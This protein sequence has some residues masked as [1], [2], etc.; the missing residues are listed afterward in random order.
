[1][2]HRRSASAWSHPSPT[3]ALGST[4]RTPMSSPS[5]RF[6][7]AMR[8][9][10]TRTSCARTQTSREDGASWTPFAA[11]SRSDSR[12]GW[13]RALAPLEARKPG[14]ARAPSPSGRVR[15]DAPR[16]REP[17]HAGRGSPCWPSSRANASSDG[18]RIFRPGNFC[19]SQWRCG[20][21]IESS[22]RVRNTSQLLQTAWVMCSASRCSSPCVISSA[23]MPSS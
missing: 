12:A 21:M 8:G 11:T 9:R 6:G 1:M 2:R 16:P 15:R 23:R 17:L 22:S 7:A 10:S 19:S 18:K 4:S 20:V 3:P 14:L 13:R 5:T